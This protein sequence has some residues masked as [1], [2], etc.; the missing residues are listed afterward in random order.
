MDIDNLT[1]KEVEA[2]SYGRQFKLKIYLSMNESM[3]RDLVN[4]ILE[5]SG[6]DFVM[7]IIKSNLSEDEWQ[8]LVNKFKS[9]E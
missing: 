9:Q 4:E 3:T 2:R 6:D 7:E 8:T 5:A 1:I